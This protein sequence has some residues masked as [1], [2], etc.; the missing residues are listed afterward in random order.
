MSNLLPLTDRA[1]AVRTTRHQRGVRFRLAHQVNLLQWQRP[2]LVARQVHAELLEEYGTV[3]P[4]GTLRPGGASERCW[5]CG[6]RDEGDGWYL[7]LPGPIA[8]CDAACAVVLAE[9]TREELA[10]GRWVSLFT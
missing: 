5:A 4:F 6:R 10:A 1:L 7:W 9:R 8:V 2:R 3:E